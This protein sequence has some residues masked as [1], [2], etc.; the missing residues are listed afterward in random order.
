M[1]W[2]VT[3]ALSVLVAGCGQGDHRRT[4]PEVYFADAQKA[5]LDGK[6]WK[7]QSLFRNLLS[8]FPGSVYVD[9]AQYG[10]GQSYVCNKDYI[11]AI[12]EFGRLLNEYPVSP[13]VDK[14]RFQIGMCYFRQS[15][16]IHR[17]QEETERAIEEFTR[18]LED[19]PNS[20]IAP[21]ARMRIQDLRDKL[22][23]KRLMHARNYLKWRYPAAAAV[24]A[25][26]VLEEH[27][28]SH[29][30][31]EARFLLAK[32]LRRQGELDEA[33]T[34]LQG[35]KT[36][37]ISDGLR[38]DVEKELQQLKRD[39]AKQVS[40][41]DRPGSETVTESNAATVPHPVAP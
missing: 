16:D 10:L 31:K 1:G 29:V 9:D 27:S 36:D 15:R 14:A 6:C 8:D 30:S 40:V 20:E 26:L 35:L 23:R 28:G 38:K 37:E 32:A 25:R 17:D 4:S 33:L 12:F 21:E 2:I 22:A 13:F 18:F 24:Y 5:L 11:S 19:F 7:A 3:L 34:L 39:V 41:S